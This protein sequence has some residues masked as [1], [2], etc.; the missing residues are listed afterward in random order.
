MQPSTLASLC[1]G[2]ALASPSPLPAALANP[3]P[4]FTIATVDAG[5]IATPLNGV[6]ALQIQSNLPPG[7][8]GRASLAP[9]DTATLVMFGDASGQVAALQAALASG[10]SLTLQAQFNLGGGLT[11]EVDLTGVTDLDLDVPDADDPAGVS[12]LSV[13]FSSIQF[14]VPPPPPDP[15]D[16][17]G[18]PAAPPPSQVAAGGGVTFGGGLP[19][20]TFSLWVDGTPVGY[21]DI[22]S[23]QGLPILKLLSGS[24]DAASCKVPRNSVVSCQR[25]WTGDGDLCGL[26][27]DG[28]TY[29]VEIDGNIPGQG[30][31]DLGNCR[32]D[33]WLLSATNGVAVTETTRFTHSTRKTHEKR[34]RVPKGTQ[35]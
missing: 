17:S 5:G 31:L 27:G 25:D 11:Q 28:G 1:L 21:Q 32:F 12:T 26:V 2:L 15:G 4:T 10:A 16:G 14:P 24:P 8:D 3:G 35:G 23:V 33:G 9:V 18:N 19:T 34:Q 20:Q 29:V 30:S 7:R 6:S 13:R 22:L